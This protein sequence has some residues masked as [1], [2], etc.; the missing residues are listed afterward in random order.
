MQLKWFSFIFSIVIKYRST[1][2]G[3]NSTDVND[4]AF[5]SLELHLLGSKSK[6]CQCDQIPRKWSCYFLQCFATL[7][8][9][10]GFALIFSTQISC[11]RCISSCHQGLVVTMHCTHSY[12][13]EGLKHFRISASVLWWFEEENGRKRC[14]VPESNKHFG[15]DSAFV[16]TGVNLTSLH[17]ADR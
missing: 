4:W 13:I 6:F 5:T 8:V 16:Y 9:S 15:P 11:S 1:V 12:S 10:Q 2:A 3:H 14:Q 17:P 7:E